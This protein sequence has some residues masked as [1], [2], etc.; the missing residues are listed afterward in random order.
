MSKSTIRTALNAVLV[1]LL[2]IKIYDLLFRLLILLILKFEIINSTVHYS[3]I[4]IFALVSV[5]LLIIV[6]KKIIGTTDRTMIKTYSLIGLNLLVFAGI[7]IAHRLYVDYLLKDSD[8]IEGSQLLSLINLSDWVGRIF[9]LLALAYFLW[10]L[11]AVDK[12]VANNE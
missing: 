6:L 12:T 2:V 11:R 3:L 4:S 1:Y 7:I 9:P 10:Q 5:L 8:F